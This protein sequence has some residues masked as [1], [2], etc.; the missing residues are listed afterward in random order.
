MKLPLILTLEALRGMDPPGEF[1]AWKLANEHH[2]VRMIDKYLNK[3]RHASKSGK[4]I[5][6]LVPWEI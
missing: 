6:L 5:I 1:V 2:S 3:A 4:N